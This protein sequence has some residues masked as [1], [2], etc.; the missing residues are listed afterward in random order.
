LQPIAYSKDRYSELENGRVYVRCVCFVHGIRSSRENNA[1]WFPGQLSQL[2]G[3][4]EHLRVD[5]KLTQSSCNQVR[6]L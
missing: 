4:R 2:L 3:A 6:V 1:F 5:I